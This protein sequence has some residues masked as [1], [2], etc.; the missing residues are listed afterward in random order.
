MGRSPSLRSRD[1]HLQYYVNNEM[2]ELS[3]RAGDGDFR[4]P[5]GRLSRRRCSRRKTRRPPTAS[6]LFVL[7]MRSSGCS[8]NEEQ[9]NLAG[10]ATADSKQD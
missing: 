5:G 8:R 1:I 10:P 2:N 7:E 9:Y 6:S 3:L 4:A